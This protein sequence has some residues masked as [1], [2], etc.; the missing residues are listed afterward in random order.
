MK[1]IKNVFTTI[2]LLLMTG[3]LL[4]CSCTTGRYIYVATPPNNPYF[5]KKGD[6]KIGAYYSSSGGNIAENKFARGTDLKGAYAAGKQWALAASYSDRK[7]KDVY[8]YGGYQSV[9]R[10]SEVNYKRNFA[11]FA[12]G[13]FAAINPKKTITLNFFAGGG[14]GKFSFS[15]N[16]YDVNK[17]NYSRYYSANSTKLFFQPSINFITSEYF[18]FALIL[19]SSYVHYKN[20]ETNYTNTELEYFRLADLNKHTFNFVEPA[21]SF[22]F[23]L[24]KYPW[25]KIE[26]TLSNVANH[27]FENDNIR[28]NN[29][30]VGFTF[31]ISKMK[32]K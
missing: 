11:E 6:S 19:K 20:T 22:Q 13:I 24:P 16:G 30:S 31:D 12:A 21:W 9:F 32:M 3:S 2:P 26:W 15:D 8:D 5:V 7:E 14:T 17:A 28:Q 10:N 27:P 29:Y 4:F 1:R 23:G 18:R 25:I